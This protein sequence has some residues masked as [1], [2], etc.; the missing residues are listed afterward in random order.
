MNYN[1]G[2]H[3]VAGDPWP[4]EADGVGSS[5]VRK[6]PE[7]Y[8]NDVTNWKAASPSPSDVNL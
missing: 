4:S 6:E 2:S 1:D 7:D 3:P 8:G 5:L